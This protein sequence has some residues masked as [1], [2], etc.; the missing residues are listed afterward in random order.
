[1]IRDL[2]TQTHI[3]DQMSLWILYDNLIKH[4]LLITKLQHSIFIPFR[5]EVLVKF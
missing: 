4:G 1:M 5:P 2:V 3:W